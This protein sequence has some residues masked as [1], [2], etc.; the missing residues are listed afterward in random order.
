V[1]PTCEFTLEF[2]S[3]KND[4]DCVG[5]EKPP[6]DPQAATRREFSSTDQ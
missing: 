3:L 1:N 5:Q 2:L 6:G 4:A